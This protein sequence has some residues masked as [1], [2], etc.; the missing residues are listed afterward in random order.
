MC[1]LRTLLPEFFGKCL[2]KEEYR[3]YH[4]IAQSVVLPKLTPDHYRVYVA[5]YHNIEWE[6]SEA[7]LLFRQTICLAEYIKAQDY[8]S[9]FVLVGD[10]SDANLMNYLPKLSILQCKQIFNILMEGFGMRVKQIHIISKSKLVDGLVMFL[11]KMLS[12]K[13]FDRLKMHKSIE[14]L[15]EYFPKTILP[16]DYGGDERSLDTLQAEWIDVLS[17]DEYLKYL[18]EMNAATTNESCRPKDQFSEHYA[19]MPGTFRYLTVD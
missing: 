12:A 6:A 2:V 3:R 1:T 7:I 17:S 13:I 8:L 19:G 15:Y 18:Q 4:K 16:K 11:K 10:F 9:G 5:K 14:D